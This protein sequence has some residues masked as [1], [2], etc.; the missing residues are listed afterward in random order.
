MSL[1][2]GLEMSKITNSIKQIWSNFRNKEYRDGFVEDTIADSL[3]VQIQ[4]MRQRRGWTQQDLADK[5]GTK[6]A[7]VCRWENSEPP[8]SL[9][10]LTKIASAFD[11]ALVVKF[12]PFS[13][14]LVGD[15]EPTDKDVR[16]YS[17]DSLVDVRGFTVSIRPNPAPQTLRES[18][19]G[20]ISGASHSG[21]AR[22]D[23]GKPHTARSSA[24]AWSGHHP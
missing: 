14:F 12:V 1:S 18:G 21:F 6:Q 13:D 15:G 3:A 20:G 5:A 8:A 22:S 2:K 16:S 11:V 17:Q 19:G 4:R 10:T 24:L 23:A 9:K 7:G